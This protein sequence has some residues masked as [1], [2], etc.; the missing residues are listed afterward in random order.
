MRLEWNADRLRPYWFDERKVC[1]PIG[2]TEIFV[3]GVLNPAELPK[4]AMLLRTEPVDRFAGAAPLVSILA[5][6][7]Y[8]CSLRR[9]E[10]AKSS[11]VSRGTRRRL[12]LFELDQ[13]S[14]QSP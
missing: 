11:S 6:V 4:R 12:P 5:A 13:R 2:A 1:L 3:V 10:P 9:S 7:K 8:T 14:L